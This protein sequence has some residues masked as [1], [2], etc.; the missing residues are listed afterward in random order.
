MREREFPKDLLKALL[1]DPSHDAQ[2]STLSALKLRPNVKVDTLSQV[3]CYLRDYVSKDLHK[4]SLDLLLGRWTQLPEDILHCLVSSLIV[5]LKDTDTSVRRSTANAI[6]RQSALPQE[7][8][9]GLIA[10]LKDT[11]TNVRRSAADALNRQSALPQE[12]LMGLIALLKDT[13]SDV[14]KAATMILV[15]RPILNTTLPSLSEH[16]WRV[17]CSKWLKRSLR[18][19]IS[20]FMCDGCNEMLNEICFDEGQKNTFIDIMQE[21]RIEAGYPSEKPLDRS[22]AYG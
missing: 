4:R 10:L 18:E 3:S 14:S 6:S 8:L 15:Q 19:D 12:A 1:V 7:A 9:T 17:L 5:L 2:I 13:N 16:D 21:A 20:C 22:S 11:D